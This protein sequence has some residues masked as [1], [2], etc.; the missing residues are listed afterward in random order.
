MLTDALGKGGA[1]R[2]AGGGGG[3][4]EGAGCRGMGVVGELATSMGHYQCSKI[5]FKI[6][7]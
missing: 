5:G 2:Q 3:G 4:G 7:L 6:S 1:M